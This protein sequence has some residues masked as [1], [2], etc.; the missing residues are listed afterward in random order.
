L[1]FLLPP[2]NSDTLQHLLHFLHTVAFHA[3][4]RHAADGAEVR[5]A[6]VRLSRKSTRFLF[7]TVGAAGI[8][9]YSR[10]REGA[11][12]VPTG[13]EPVGP[14]PGATGD[15]IAVLIKGIML[16]IM[17]GCIRGWVK[18]VIVSATHC[19]T[20]LTARYCCFSFFLQMYLL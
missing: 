3:D 13:I 9:E 11:D 15:D 4:D 17:L 8:R 1:I 7:F 14:V 20:V 16:V 12:R 18:L 2:C 5:F 19:L 10:S 6:R